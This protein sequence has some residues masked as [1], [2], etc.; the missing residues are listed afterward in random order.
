MSYFYTFV[1]Y[2]LNLNFKIKYLFLRISI[3]TSILHHVLSKIISN[4]I[5]FTEDDQYLI[6][7]WSGQE[8]ICVLLVSKCNFSPQNKRNS[9]LLGKNVFKAKLL[10]KGNFS[11]VENTQDTHIFKPCSW[12]S[13]LADVNNRCHIYK[14]YKP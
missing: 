14:P 6:V 3:Y 4:Y 2:I 11:G 13:H 1:Q 9:P 5:I 10:L 7:L 12:S 8:K